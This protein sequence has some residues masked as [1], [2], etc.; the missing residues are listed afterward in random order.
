M[1]KSTYWI[2]LRPMNSIENS[3]KGSR[4]D[5]HLHLLKEIKAKYFIKSN[6]E[7]Q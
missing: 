1:N 5:N 3:S 2:N 6:D 7:K 4:I